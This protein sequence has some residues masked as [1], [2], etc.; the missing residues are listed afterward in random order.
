MSACDCFLEAGETNQQLYVK[1]M[2]G[3][4]VWGIGEVSLQVGEVGG[5]I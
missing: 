1:Q 3:S 2:Q 4:K 5:L